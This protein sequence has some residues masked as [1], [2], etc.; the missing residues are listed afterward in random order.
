MWVCLKLGEAPKSLL[1]FG[2]SFKHRNNMIPSNPCKMLPNIGPGSLS[3]LRVLEQA[4][5]SAVTALQVDSIGPFRWRQRA[6]VT[7]PAVPEI[8]SNTKKTNKE[9]SFLGRPLLIATKS[10]KK[11]TT[12]FSGVLQG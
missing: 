1:A 11:K 10:G 2:L 12:H 5:V 3:I 9:V 8:A 4:L 7:Q 6:Q